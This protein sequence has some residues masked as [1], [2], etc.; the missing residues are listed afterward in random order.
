[1]LSINK[2]K[3]LKSLYQKKN[4]LVENKAI[5]EGFRIINEAINSGLLFEHIWI[6]EK[7]NSNSKENLF[8]IKKLDKNN[9][10]YSFEKDKD[11]QSISSTKNSQGIIGLFT[12]HNFFNT[13]KEDFSNN[14]IILDQIS[15][16]GNLGTI[17]RTC[18]WYDI[19]TIILSES[20]SDIFNPKCLRSGMGGH[21]YIKDFIYLSYNEIIDFIKLNNY[22]YYCSSMEGESIYNLPKED[23]WVLVLGSEAHGISNDLLFGEKITIPRH[24]KIDSLNVSIASGIIIDY[25]KKASS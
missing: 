4:R 21:F 25:L 18:A 12:T 14:I 20:T 22:K 13:A 1:M 23:K 5:I 15:D 19:K 10:P 8:F 6:S 9:I 17:I 2:K 11:I 24:G 16:P 7:Y 3:Y